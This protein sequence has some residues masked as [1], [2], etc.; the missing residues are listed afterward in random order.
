MAE[1][2]IIALDAMGGDNA[3]GEIVKG[4][5]EAV[6][7]ESGVMVYLVG[8]QELVNA[9]LSKHTYN[10]AFAIYALS[11]YYD[12]T[13]NEE[14][15]EIASPLAD[16]DHICIA[17]ISMNLGL[18]YLQ[19]GDPLRAKPFFETAIPVF[20]KNYGPEHMKTRLAKSKLE[21]VQSVQ[22]P[23]SSV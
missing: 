19:G 20:D 11:S 7:M 6:N 8:R 5:V 17:E 3:P 12:A 10:Q 14:A 23:Q 21:S 1:K 16:R 22:T 4:A 2:V 13:G 9:E 18:L 15:L